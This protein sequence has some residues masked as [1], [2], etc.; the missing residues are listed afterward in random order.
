MKNITIESPNCPNCGAD[1]DNVSFNYRALNRAWVNLVSGPPEDPRV[2][3][4]DVWE[5][6]EFE[7]ADI[8]CSSCGKSWLDQESFA[9][10]V[11]AAEA[12][13]G[14]TA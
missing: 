7:F 4:G 1:N 6:A 8:D 3:S 12:K 9:K 11:I 13:K 14:V 2:V 5:D 10:D